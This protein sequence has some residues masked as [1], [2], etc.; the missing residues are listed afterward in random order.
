MK[1]IILKLIKASLR[2]G[3]FDITDQ[4]NNSIATNVSIYSLISGVV[5]DVDDSVSVVILTST[6]ICKQSISMEVSTITPTQLS[7][8]VF[9]EI[10]TACL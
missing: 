2:V 1:T 10:N 3:P 8:Q 4:Y 7:S 6:G 9:T 5:Y